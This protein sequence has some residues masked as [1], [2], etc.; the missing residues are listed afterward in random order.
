[1]QTNR[2][3]SRAEPPRAETFGPDAFRGLLRVGAIALALAALVSLPVLFSVH[4]P[5]DPAQNREWALQADSASYRLGWTLQVYALAPLMVGLV[6][7]FVVLGATRARGVALVGMLVTLGAA[8][9]FLSGMAYPV[10]VMPAAGIMIRQG[11]DE[12]ILRL[13]D[14]VFRE[15]AWIPVFLAGFVYNIGWIIVGVALW[16]SHVFPRWSGALVMA[17]GVIGIPAFLDMTAVQMVSP[18]V[19][20]AAALTLA[21]GLWRRAGA[22]PA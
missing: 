21:V 16:R 18:L 14:Q 19:L 17:V 20:A 10:I 15:P 11:A 13:L 4:P 1:M 3:V 12:P 8:G 9:V 7:L 22:M 6:A 2:R 5:T